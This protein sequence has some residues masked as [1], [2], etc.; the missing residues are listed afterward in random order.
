MISSKDREI[1]SI[2]YLRSVFE[3]MKKY[4][5]TKL[6]IN[7]GEARYEIH[8]GKELEEISIERQEP[9]DSV[10]KGAN[11]ILTSPEPEKSKKEVSETPPTKEENVVEV[12]TPIVGTFYRAP[13]PESEPFVD[14]GSHVKKG[15]ILCIVEAMKSMNEI[16]SEVEGIVQEVL[17]ENGKMVEYDQPLFKVK[18]NP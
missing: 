3:E 1:I 15:D 18:A 8:R 16:E 13:S 4:D 10:S 7:R 14:V 5:I 2:E 11:E 12:K 17:V 9:E 6:V